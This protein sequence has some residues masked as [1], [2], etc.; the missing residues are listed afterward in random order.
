VLENTVD[1][2]EGEFHFRAHQVVNHSQ[3]FAT[4]D[5]VC[6]NCGIT[7]VLAFNRLDAN[8]VE[9]SWRLKPK[10][11]LYLIKFGIFIITTSIIRYLFFFSLPFMLLYSNTK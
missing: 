5:Q 6:G 7:G 1:Y 2:D 11:I 4:T 3:N 9:N 10:T 8:M